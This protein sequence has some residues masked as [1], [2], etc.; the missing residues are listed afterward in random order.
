M[1]EA[2]RWNNEYLDSLKNWS[3]LPVR[4]Q[5]LVNILIEIRQNILD[6]WDD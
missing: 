1:V 4:D 5:D 3:Y 2:G 6:I